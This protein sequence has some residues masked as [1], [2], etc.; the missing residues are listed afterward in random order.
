M[1][2]NIIPFRSHE[3]CCSCKKK[4]EKEKGAKRNEKKR[5]EKNEK[6]NQS[7]LEVNEIYTT[8]F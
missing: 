1:K 6:K 5:N 8:R 4:N 7:M 3:S 2:C